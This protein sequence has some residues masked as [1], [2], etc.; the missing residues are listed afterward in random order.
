M[1]RRARLPAARARRPARRPVH[2]PAPGC[3]VPTPPRCRRGA[4]AHRDQ[5]AHPPAR[6]RRPHSLTDPPRPISTLPTEGS[7]RPMSISI[8]D[9]DLLEDTWA[10]AVPHDQFD[11]LRAEAPVHWHDHP[12]S[13]GFWAV[14][15]YDD[16]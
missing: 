2:R 16:V 15:R 10:V 13:K 1:V 3:R 5:R 11:F 12:E 4:R 7:D 6:P 8:S 14:T 9:I